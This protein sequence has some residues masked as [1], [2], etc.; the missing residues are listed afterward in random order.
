MPSLS[1]APINLT[2]TIPNLHRLSPLHDHQ[3]PVERLL[4]PPPPLHQL[5]PQRRQTRTPANRQPPPQLLFNPGTLLHH[6]LAALALALSDGVHGRSEEEANG[7]VDVVFRGDGREGEFGEGFGDADDGFELADGDGDAGA[8]VCGNFRRVDLP[9]DGDEVG[10]ELF[11][12]FGR[13]AGRAAS[14]IYGEL[15]CSLRKGEMEFLTIC[16]S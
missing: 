2:P 9:A 10:R 3:R 14:G 13:E 16:N 11:A 4:A 7:F 6:L 8:G 1:T 15:Y 5:P 12:G